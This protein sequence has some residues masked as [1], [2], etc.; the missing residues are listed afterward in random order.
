[1]GFDLPVI[2][3]T[4]ITDPKKIN[5]NTDY[6]GTTMKN[7]GITFSEGSGKSPKD[8]RLWPKAAWETGAI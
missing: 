3:P 5:F 7:T 4:P 8:G 2:G 6:N 1:M